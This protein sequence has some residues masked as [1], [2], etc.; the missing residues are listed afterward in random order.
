MAVHGI[1]IIESKKGLFVSMPATS[2]IDSEG[3]TKY[4]DICHPITAE[5][6]TALINSV[7]D[8]YKQALAQKAGE[9]QSS[10][11]KVSESEDEALD[12]ELSDDEPFNEEMCPP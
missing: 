2:Y 3:N 9:T 12:D 5:S 11:E 6:R 7:M 4:S 1:R 10:A 8:A